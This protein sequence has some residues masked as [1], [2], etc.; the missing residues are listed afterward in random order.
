MSLLGEFVRIPEP[1][2][3]KIYQTRSLSRTWSF[4]VRS[5]CS[6]A[7]SASGAVGRAGIP[8]SEKLVLQAILA[9]FAWRHVRN[10]ID[11]SW[12]RSPAPAGRMESRTLDPS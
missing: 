10:A 11:R 5:W 8:V 1:L 4:G 7:A 2:C 3:T 6:V 12:R 9:R